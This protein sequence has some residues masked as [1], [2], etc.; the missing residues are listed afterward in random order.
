MGGRGLG[1]WARAGSMRV[2]T[3]AA[4]RVVG[5]HVALN[6][7]RVHKAT[8]VKVCEC[9]CCGVTQHH[10]CLKPH[11]ACPVGFAIFDPRTQ[12]CHVQHQQ[13]TGAAEPQ[14]WAGGAQ[15][16]PGAA[17]RHGAQGHAVRQ[18][19]GQRGGG[20]G[21]GGGAGYGGRRR[22]RGGGSGWQLGEALARART[23]A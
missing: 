13:R 16:G 2:H 6:W 21:S 4:V 17:G 19:G 14:G 3:Y 22:G 20:G 15:A 10:R 5:W 23:G 11:E 9:E 18:R 12:H 1:H 8:L 7:A